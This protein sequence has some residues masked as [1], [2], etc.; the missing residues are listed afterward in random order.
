MLSRCE[1]PVVS[2][3]T[4][5]AGASTTVGGKKKRRA[6]S[7]TPWDGLPDN[8]ITPSQAIVK[9]AHDGI[10]WFRHERLSG[11]ADFFNGCPL[12][13]CPHRGGAVAKAGPN[14]SGVQ[15]Y[16]CS[17]CGRVSA[18][19]TGTV[20]DNSKL[21]ITAWI[22]F[23]LQALSFESIASMTREDRRADTTPPYWMAKIFEVLE[24]GKTTFFLAT[25]YGLT[26]LSIP[27]PTRTPCA[28][29]TANC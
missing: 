27:L 10:N 22:D 28:N 20:F 8:Q 14:R 13:S 11:D 26:S 29:R 2:P 16:R 25:G 3:S 6:P 1:S 24:G 12:S 23:I 4:Q 7:A 21:P 9:A 5:A 19:V 18:P 15:R 17:L